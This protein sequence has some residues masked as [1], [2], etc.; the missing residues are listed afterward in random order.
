[1]TVAVFAVRKDN[2]VGGFFADGIFAGVRECDIELIWFTP[3]Q[4]GCS[5]W[6]ECRAQF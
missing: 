3:L 6:A 5:P 4:L 2:P 1:M